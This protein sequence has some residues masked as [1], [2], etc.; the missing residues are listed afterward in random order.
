MQLSVVDFPQPD[1]P[2]RAMNSPR[3]I[4]RRNVAQRIERPEITAHTVEP[5][6]IELR[7]GRS[8]IAGP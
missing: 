2:S 5:D 4:D 6:F 8:V 3:R 1:G 7:K